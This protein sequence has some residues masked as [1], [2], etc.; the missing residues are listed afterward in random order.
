MFVLL[1]GKG[2]ECDA[3]V[4]VLQ[5]EGIEFRRIEGD[6]NQ[7]AEE[8]CSFTHVMACGGMEESVHTV[9]EVL[10]LVH[11]LG[12]KVPRIIALASDEKV[13]RLL[14]RAGAELVL[15]AGALASIVALILAHPYAGMLL[16]KALLEDK[17]IMEEC[18]EM[19]CD[20]YEMAKGGIPLGVYSRRGWV[21]PGKM[22]IGDVLIYIK[23]F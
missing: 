11:E 6:V 22:K 10:A 7:V 16:Y 20:A 13:A 1:I 5:E 15:P 12:C 4:E 18:T 23:P 21:P 14:E 2:A 19:E 17:L 8:I 3:L 9:L